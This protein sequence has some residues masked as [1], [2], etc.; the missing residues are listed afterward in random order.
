[1]MLS[2]RHE[3]DVV[4]IEIGAIISEHHPRVR[5]RRYREACFVQHLVKR[6]AYP[7]ICV[8]SPK[9]VTFA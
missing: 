9:R 8:T 5:Q 2:Q 1:M 6:R 4:D 3:R 7:K